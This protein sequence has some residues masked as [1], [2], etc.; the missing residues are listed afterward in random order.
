VRQPEPAE[1]GQ[2]LSRHHG[3]VLA[4]GWLLYV[5]GIFA[6]SAV[7]W[8]L[9][10]R[11]SEAAVCA[12]V[13]VVALLVS[14]RRWNQ[15]VTVYEGGMAW[16][17]GRLIK[18]VRWEEVADVEAE[19]FDGDF[20]LTVTTRDGRELALDESI[21]DVR[22]LHGYLVNAMRGRDGGTPA[23]STSFAIRS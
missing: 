17:R 9:A 13:A 2:V 7:P 19:T 20:S 14:W 12:A 10:A 23:S 18:V 3:R 8:V 1:L 11:W 6:A 5:G 16:R 15:C 22:Q 21:A 4:G